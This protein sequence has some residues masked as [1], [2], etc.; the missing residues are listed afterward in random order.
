MD[1]DGNGDGCGVI[2]FVSLETAGSCDDS[3][4]D[5]VDDESTFAIFVRAN[6][7][8]DDDDFDEDDCL[9]PFRIVILVRRRGVLEKASI[10]VVVVVVIVIIIVV[11]I[12]AVDNNI[13]PIF[14]LVLVPF[15]EPD[16]DAPRLR[17]VGDFI[18]I[19]N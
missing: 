3:V 7:I 13:R 18:V 4:D 2:S 11:D 6:A 12:M 14:L 5:D 10:V 1:R 8:D 19:V 17:S 16:D 15:S 9:S